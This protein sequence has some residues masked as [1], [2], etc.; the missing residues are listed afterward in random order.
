M[1]TTT[2]SAIHPSA[3]RSPGRAGRSGGAPRPDPVP[4]PLPG[5]GWDTGVPVSYLREVVEH[6]RNRYDW[7]AQEEALN[8]HPQFLTE[9]DGQRV[10]F[11]HVRSPSPTHCRCCSRTAGPARSQ[12]SST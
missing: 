1:D 10:H 12:S 7:R 8:A 4:R 9:I 3:S 11:L 2:S 6:W 5:D